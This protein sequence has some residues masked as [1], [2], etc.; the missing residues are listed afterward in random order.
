MET[1]FIDIGS[2]SIK[3]L[4]ADFDDKNIIDIA[5]RSE[6]SRISAAGGL[7]DDA[8]Q[9][10]L[11]A[12]SS[13]C[14]RSKKNCKNFDVF[15]FGTSALREAKTA[16]IVLK[17]LENLGVKIRI[18]S[19]KEEAMLSFEGACGDPYLNITPTTS[20]VYGDLGGGSM[21][22]VS[23]QGSKII[24]LDSLT[25]GAVRLTNQFTENGVLNRESLK[26]H[27]A[28]LLKRIPIPQGEFKFV[29]AGGAVSAARFILG[30]GEICSRRE[31]SIE[32]FNY[33]L[34]LADELGATGLS[35]KFG[36]PKN[37][38]DILPA[39]FLCLMEVLKYFNA[40][41]FTHTKISLRYGVAQAYFKGRL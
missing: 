24:G 39:A 35:E 33:C 34:S 36:T 26:N 29:V 12:V 18:L 20:V 13:L 30:N 1:L 4:L 17:E 9:I 5:D 8:V 22:F 23:R 41:F 19:G 27:C 21:E 32:D 10:I 25:I 15:C 38:G 40:K 16:P 31:I 14:R 2:N 7:K 3:S 6:Q 28:D 37:R 11:D